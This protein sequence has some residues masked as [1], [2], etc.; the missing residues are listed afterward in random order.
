MFPTRQLITLNT[1][2]LGETGMTEYRAG[3][4]QQVASAKNVD[5]IV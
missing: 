4:A 1:P 5:V 2:V 3:T